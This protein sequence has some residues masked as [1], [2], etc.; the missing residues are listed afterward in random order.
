MK[1]FFPIWNNSCKQIEKKVR[2]AL[3]EFNM[4]D[5]INSLLIALSGGK[6]SL[7]LLFMLNTIIGR[8]FPKIKLYAIHVEENFSENIYNKK[9]LKKICD[10][11]KIDLIFQ[12]APIKKKLECYSCARERRKLIFKTAKNLNIKNIAFGH[13]K[14]DIIQTLLLN[15]FQKGCFE[16]MNPTI[17]MYNYD[18]TIIRPL[19]FTSEKEILKFATHNKLQTTKCNCL[20]ENISKRKM[21]DNLLNM[22]EKKFPLV[23]DKLFKSILKKE[24]NYDNS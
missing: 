11:L 15:L 22:I 2:K 24:K 13:H 5:N 17:Y 20:Y 10:N 8:G 7:T 16:A 4:L 21:I 1:T 9:L 23:K 18:I 12:K 3:Y 6:D 19:I 14:D